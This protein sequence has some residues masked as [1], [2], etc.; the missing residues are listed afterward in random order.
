MLE[1]YNE[2]FSGCLVFWCF[3]NN[4]FQVLTPVKPLI[5]LM[6]TEL[7]LKLIV[8]LWNV[9]HASLMYTFASLLNVGFFLCVDLRYHFATYWWNIHVHAV[10]LFGITV[11]R[12]VGKK[13]SSNFA[14]IVCRYIDDV[15]KMITK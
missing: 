2:K 11:Y 4:L 5:L 1:T 13:Y 15:V 8:L 14:R 12:T 7:W 10:N 9:F 3:Y 6:T